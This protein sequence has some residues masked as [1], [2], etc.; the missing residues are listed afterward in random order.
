MEAPNKL[1]LPERNPLTHARHRKE[2]FWQITIP[3]MIGIL[4]VLVA[5]TVVLLSATHA[6]TNLSRW[7]D[8]SL[9]WLILPSLL[10][11]FIFFIILIA[12]T[13]LITIVLKMTPPYARIIQL[14]F[15]TGKSKV[16]FYSN[17]V[18]EPIV[19]ARSVWAVLAHPSR[20]GKQP[21]GEK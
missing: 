1:I 2:V 21:P 19:K 10:I 17:K 20:Y 11:A 5:V 14:Y 7:A 12:F 9:I 8:V 13:Y 6:A 4:L 3:L 15:E 18:T 16:V